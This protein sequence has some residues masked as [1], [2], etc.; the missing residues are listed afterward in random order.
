[1]L[2][3]DKCGARS[4]DGDYGAH[5]VEQVLVVGPTES[6]N[7]RFELCRECHSGFMKWCKKFMEKE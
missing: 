4:K 5:L 1:M 3:C 6:E 2:I 7:F